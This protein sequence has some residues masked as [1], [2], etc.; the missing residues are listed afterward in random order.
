MMDILQHK[1]IFESTRTYCAFLPA[2]SARELAYFLIPARISLD[3]VYVGDSINPRYS[4][5]AR[6]WLGVR[7]QQPA[8][9]LVV[10]CVRILRPERRATGG[11]QHGAGTCSSCLCA[12]P[13]IER[14][15]E[16]SQVT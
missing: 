5:M 4:Q 1:I 16:E 9:C 14:C 11:R 13:S 6:L 3:P 15:W 2:S 7:V 8:A 12:A 10:G